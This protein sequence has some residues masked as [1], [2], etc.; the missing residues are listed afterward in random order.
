MKHTKLFTAV[1]FSMFLAF[2]AFAGND[3]QVL[4]ASLAKASSPENVKAVALQQKTMYCA[5]NAKNKQLQGKE[6]DQYLTAC[7][8][9]NEAQ[10]A[11]ET[12]SNQR[13]A[14]GDVNEM[15]RKLPT[16]AGNK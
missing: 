2:P 8:S 11:F 15:L 14:A 6:K 13:I 12:I 5:Q 4:A 7:M 1:G 9:E 10:I 3:S 16:A